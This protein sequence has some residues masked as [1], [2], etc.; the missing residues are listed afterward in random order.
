MPREEELRLHRCCFSGQ[1]PE[2]LDASPEEVKA[3][4]EKQIDRA[5]A[6]GYVTF[7]SGC[8]MGAD[9]WA[10]QIV[11][12]RRERDPRLHLIAVTPWPGFAA[13]WGEDWRRQ[14][15]QLLSRADL[16]VQVSP[17]YHEGV[18]LRRNQWMVDHAS[19]LI[20]YWNGEA[21]GT[22]DTVKYARTRGIEVVT[23]RSGEGENG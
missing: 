13:R 18:F 9:I 19:R 1:R 17:R 2:K 23:N 14:Y 15:D 20:V 5:V 3:W 11:L 4:L 16:K 8:A 12:N 21:G 10:A 22:R 7:I 6:D